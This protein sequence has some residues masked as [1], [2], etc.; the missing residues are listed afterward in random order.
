M[1]AN[2][3][4]TTTREHDRLCTQDPA[5]ALVA[6]MRQEAA[7]EGVTLAAGLCWCRAL[8][9]V[10]AAVKVLGRDCEY[11][12]CQEEPVFVT[13][14]GAGYCPDHAPEIHEDPA[15]FAAVLR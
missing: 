10:D 3:Y 1:S 15:E 7:S 5:D 2:P 12:D 11:E 4:R 9:A 13:R 14:A 8:A 6:E